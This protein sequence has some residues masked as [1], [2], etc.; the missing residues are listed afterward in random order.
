MQH[1][2]IAVVPQRIGSVSGRNAKGDIRVVSLYREHGGIKLCGPSGSLIVA[3]MEAVLPTVAT[4]Y[5]LAEPSLSLS[6]SQRAA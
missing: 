3:D 1:E 4:T 6:L 5:A 2:R